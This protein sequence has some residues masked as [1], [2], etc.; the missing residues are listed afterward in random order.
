MMKLV[1][2]THLQGYHCVL[3]QYWETAGPSCE[4]LMLFISV[5][6]DTMPLLT[7]RLNLSV[8]QLFLNSLGFHSSTCFLLDS[9]FGSHT[10]L[11]T[12]LSCSTSSTIRSLFHIPL[13]EQPVLFIQ[14][15][16]DS[17]LQ[18]NENWLIASFWVAMATRSLTA[19]SDP[20]F[21]IHWLVV[22]QHNQRNL[23]YPSAITLLFFFRSLLRT[24][25]SS[26][27]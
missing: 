9:P 11:C 4:L 15:T 26:E 27:F 12:V 25:L 14:P 8:D 22:R 24:F 2:Y 17:F 13:R 6:T 21:L 18:Q 20:H 16:K 10:N 19:C 5:H 1:V 23:H 7:F 3:S